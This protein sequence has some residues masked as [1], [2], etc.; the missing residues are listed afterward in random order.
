MSR[1]IRAINDEAASLGSFIVSRGEAS[2]R[3]RL[4]EPCAPA[5]AVGAAVFDPEPMSAEEIAFARGYDEAR[6]AFELEFAEERAALARLAQSLEVLRPE[7]AN[8]LALVIA[9]AVDRLVRDVVGSVDVDPTL[10]LARARQAAELVAANVAPTKLRAHP[11]DLV[12]LEGAE[13]QVALEGDATLPRGTIILE[14]GDGWIEDG[15]AVRLARV[16]AE[17][18]R[19]AAPS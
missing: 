6:R 5:D 7:P 2:F 3:P 13:L 18:D 10:L 15:P 11:D 9:E 17:L 12:H 8:A 4:V 14:T 16:R 19:M 1:L